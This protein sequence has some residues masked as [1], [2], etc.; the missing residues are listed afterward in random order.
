MRSSLH[1]R[2]LLYSSVVCTESI[3]QFIEL[4]SFSF[5]IYQI[6]TMY[7][8]LICC[9]C[10]Q[11]CCC[12]C[13]CGPV[14]WWARRLEARVVMN[15]T[16]YL[17]LPL[18]MNSIRIVKRSQCIG[19]QR[20]HRTRDLSKGDDNVFVVFN[21]VA[22][23]HSWIL[24]EMMTVTSGWLLHLVVFLVT[25]FQSNAQAY[26]IQV[27]DISGC[28]AGA[29][30]L[31]QPKVK[32]KDSQDIIALSFVGSA[33]IQ[34]GASPSG[35]EPLYIGTCN[36]DGQCGTKVTGRNAIVPVINGYATFQVRSIHNTFYHEQLSCYPLQWYC[37]SDIDA[38]YH[39][40]DSNTC[41]VQNVMIKTAGSGYTLKIV[42]IDVNGFAVAGVTSSTFS[43][44]VGPI[45]KL[46]FYV[47]IGSAIGGQDRKS[48]V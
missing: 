36:I 13:E 42:V 17:V 12:C 48:V 5:T 25:A 27:V 30:C 4:C 16:Y 10:P 39:F 6:Y 47:A 46:Q 15:S 11:D 8:L 18:C 31:Q 26:T 7:V 3:L 41:A 29:P 28:F 20:I 45:F 43:V 35:F 44:A 32:I 40:L 24:C 23:D 2:P 1:A 9:T 37:V 34:I 33:Y 14:G 38:S 22:A 19:F 21:D